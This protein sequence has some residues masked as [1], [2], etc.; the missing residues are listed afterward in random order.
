MNDIVEQIRETISE[1][2]EVKPG[3]YHIEVLHDDDCPAL[4]T[5]RLLDCVCKPIIRRKKD[6]K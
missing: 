5:E 4:R 2:G 6:K 3:F 1:V